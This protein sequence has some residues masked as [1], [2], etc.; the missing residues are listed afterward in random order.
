VSPDSR[1]VSPHLNFFIEA[2]ALTDEYPTAYQYESKA[3]AMA[4]GHGEYL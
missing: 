3:A 4:T 2:S 1:E